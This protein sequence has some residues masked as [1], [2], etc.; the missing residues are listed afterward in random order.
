[1]EPRLSAYFFVTISPSI[2]EGFPQTIYE[3]DKLKIIRAVRKASK[4]YIIYPEFAYPSGRLHY[5]GII[6]VND[7]IAWCK[8]TLPRFR[9]LGFTDIKPIRQKEYRLNFILQGKIE[10]NVHVYK[11]VSILSVLL[12]IRKMWPVT[13][14]ILDLDEPI[15]PKKV[16]RKRKLVIG[17]SGQEAITD[18]FNIVLKGKEYE[19]MYGTNNLRKYFV[20]YKI[21]NNTLIV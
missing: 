13:K 20:Q 12:Y 9:M 19:K 1:M 17:E 7:M 18:Y 16:V 14:K 3:D 10:K 8:F 2:R 4:H 6:V 5:H 21:N 11:D 15:Y